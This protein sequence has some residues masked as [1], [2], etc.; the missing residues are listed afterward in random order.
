MNAVAVPDAKEAA[1]GG[2]GHDVIAIGGSAGAF[3]ALRSLVRDLSPDLPATVLIAVHTSPDAPGLLAEVLDGI[4]PWPVGMAEEGQRIERGRIYVAPPDRHLLVMS[5]HLHV[6]R[7]PRENR[8]R[9]AIDPLFRSAA[10]CCSSRVIGVLLSGMLNDGTSG[11]RAI[12]RCRGLTVVQDPRDAAFPEMPRHALA[13]VAVDHVVPLA[14][15]AP[16]LLE[17][18]RSPRPPPLAEAP[19][20]IHVEALIAAQELTVMPDQHRLGQLSPLA[21]PDCHGSMVEIQDG[22]LLRF[23]CH[24]GHAFT[25]ETLRLAKC[26]A[27][28][29][30]LYAAMRAQQ[31]HAMLA[32]RI[33]AEADAKGL[34]R[35]AEDFTRRGRDYEEGAEVIRQ[36]LARGNGD[37][38]I[39]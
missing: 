10:V 37:L 23:R 20:E 3:D 18:A 31:E 12:Q 7:G 22:D 33:A 17:L 29:R 27:W 8:S 19:K 14:E 2:D 35:S 34:V 1:L 30:T 16:L 32:R 36:L 11:L 6:R 21:C 13:H 25:L 39:D 5:D 9:P 28:E 24:T 38:L 26:E 15:L 4:G